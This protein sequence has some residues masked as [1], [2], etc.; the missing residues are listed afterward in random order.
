MLQNKEK[1]LKSPRMCQS[2][3]G[4]S[5]NEIERLLPTFEECLIAHRYRLKPKSKR[6]RK[7]GGGRKGDLPTTQDKLLYIL[8]YLKVYPVYD[9]LSVLSNHQRSK[10]GDSIQLLLP[11]LEMALGRNLVLPKRK[12]RSMEEVFERCPELKDVFIDGTERR[13]QRPKSIKK[14]NKLYSGKKKSTTKKTVVLSN[15]KRGVLYMTPS[16]SGRR[17]DK[18][19]MDKYDV[20]RYIPDDVTAWTDTGF[21]GLQYAHANTIMPKKR[22]KNKSLTGEEKQENKVISGLRIVSEHAIGGFKRFRATSDIYRN[23]LPNMDDTMNRVCAGLWNLH[24]GQ[25]V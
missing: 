6:K 8:M 13:T 21:Q 7:V 2:V 16:R 3:F 1:I 24:L 14:R 22:R 19:T 20:A 4:M 17:H 10:C 12:A 15:E 11:V 18:R 9:I 23:K 5:K 25:I